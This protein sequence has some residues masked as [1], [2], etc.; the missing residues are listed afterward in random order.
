MTQTKVINQLFEMIG[1]FHWKNKAKN[2]EIKILFRRTPAFITSRSE[3]KSV[4]SI[5]EHF[6]RQRSNSLRKMLFSRW[7]LHCNIGNCYLLICAWYFH[8]V[9][10]IAVWKKKNILDHCICFLMQC[11]FFSHVSVESYLDHW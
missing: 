11:I 2:K 8:E 4:R 9:D 1:L 7:S 10:C 6:V 5:V 3:Q